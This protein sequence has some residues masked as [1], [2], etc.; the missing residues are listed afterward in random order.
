VLNIN[1]DSMASVGF[2]PPTRVFEAAGAAACLICDT[3]DGIE[4][5]LQPQ[6]EVI[7]VRSGAEV[8]DE[9]AA[10]SAERARRIGAAARE[11]VLAEHTY[12]HR[13]VQLRSLFEGRSEG[14]VWRSVSNA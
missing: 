7:C 13:G 4:A 14:A 3:W 5:F 11:R 6:R 8:A 2:S 12:E 1:R 10:L 9:L